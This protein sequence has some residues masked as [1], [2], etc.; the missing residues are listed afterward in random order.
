[1]SYAEFR[2]KARL[3]CA[4]DYEAFDKGLLPLIE[5]IHGGT[6]HCGKH[7]RGTSPSVAAREREIRILERRLEQLVKTE[8]FEDAARVR[9]QIKSLKSSKEKEQNDVR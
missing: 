6:Q 3:G 9:D 1:M 8:K 2:A 5:K 7:I 4:N